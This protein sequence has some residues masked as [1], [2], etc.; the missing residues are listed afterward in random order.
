VSAHDGVVGLRGTVERFSKRRAAAEDADKIDGVYE[1]INHLKVDVVGTDSRTDD[2]I[3]G[4]ALQSLIWDADVPSDSV[5]VKVQD[6]W[7]TLKGHVGQQFHSDAA[8]DDA[9]RL[10]GV[11]GITNDHGHDPPDRSRRGSG[12]GGRLLAELASRACAVSRAV[13]DQDDLVAWA[14]RGRDAQRT[15]CGIGRATSRT[16]A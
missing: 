10:Y 4:A 1:V 8:Y 16:G 6:G 5:D 15:G 3:R 7:V 9:S 2:E 13:E 11:F 12:A 14:L